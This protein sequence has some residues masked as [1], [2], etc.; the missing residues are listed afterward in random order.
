MKIFSN[1]FGIGDRKVKHL[2]YSNDD[3]YQGDM[4]SDRREGF[5]VYKFTNGNKYEG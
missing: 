1:L 4:V 5:G 3:E 2:K